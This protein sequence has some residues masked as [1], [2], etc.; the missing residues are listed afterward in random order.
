MM[1]M[2]MISVI[3]G[4]IAVCFDTDSVQHSSD[5]VLLGFK[6]VQLNVES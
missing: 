3:I 4:H 6:K 1:T 5:I 2:M